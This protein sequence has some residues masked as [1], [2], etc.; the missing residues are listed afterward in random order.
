[1]MSRELTNLDI[2]KYLIISADPLVSMMRQKEIVKKKE[3]D[4]E[5]KSLMLTST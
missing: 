2:L 1:M 3:L 5:V 4:V